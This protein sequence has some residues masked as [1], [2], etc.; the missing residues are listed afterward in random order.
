MRREMLGLF[1]KNGI[2]ASTG[3]SGM[4]W[5]DPGQYVRVPDVSVNHIRRGV[6]SDKPASSHLAS[7]QNARMWHPKALKSNGGTH[8]N[9]GSTLVHNAS[10]DFINSLCG[11]SA[12]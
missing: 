5:D 11:T 9:F 6:S 3:M 8:M 7:H 2:P 1:G 12:L 4:A 10:V